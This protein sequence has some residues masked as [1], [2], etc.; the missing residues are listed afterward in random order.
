MIEKIKEEPSLIATIEPEK[1]RNK[2][3]INSCGAR[4]TELV[5]G[6]QKILTSV[7]RGDGKYGSSHPCVPIFGPETT[8]SYGL[9]QH[10]SAR[11]RNFK[12]LSSE[13]YILLSQKVVDGKYPEGLVIEQKHTLAN[14][15]YALETMIRNYSDLDL[16]V[17][18]AH[19]F[20][21]LASN[22]PE[23]VRINGVDAT[24]MIKRNSSIKIEQE[25]LIEIPGQKP[26]VLKQKGFSIFQLWVYKNPKTGEYDKNY[27][28]I[29]PAEGDPA[30]N[31]FGSEKS[32]IKS[33]RFRETE[34][35]IRLSEEN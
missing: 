12:I 8:T 24:D 25:N 32:M 7:T 15:T 16:P 10:G 11:D 2:L 13:P 23:G 14:G 22:G 17:N 6:R 33:R 3:T 20:Y 21:W 31:Y 34:I 4:I 35:L 18:F 26:V 5:L 30:E 9:P 19:H 27:V 28:C 29:E 1:G